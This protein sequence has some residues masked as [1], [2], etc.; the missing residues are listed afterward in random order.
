[1][2][3][4]IEVQRGERLHVEWINT[5]RTDDGRFARHPVVAVRECP[6]YVRFA[7]DSAPHA[8]ENLLG[9]TLAQRD[10]TAA[11]LPPWTVVHLH[12]GRTSADVDG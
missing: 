7:D 1:V 5:L 4:T 8:A 10:A 12:G 6:A 2:G 3:P 9:F 11:I